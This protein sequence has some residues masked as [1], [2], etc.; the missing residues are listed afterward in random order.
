MN[1]YFCNESNNPWYQTD[2][3]YWCQPCRDKHDLHAVITAFDHCK[4]VDHVSLYVQFPSGLF[5]V[6][7][8]MQNNCTSIVGAGG[9]VHLTVPGLFINLNNVKD[10]LKLYLLFS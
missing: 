1:C 7:L 4:E 9:T 5:S 2:S 8:K 6:T 10:K 3:A